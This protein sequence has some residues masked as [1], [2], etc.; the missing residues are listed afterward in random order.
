MRGEVG[1]GNH[2]PWLLGCL[3]PRTPSPATS[4]RGDQRE[5]GPVLALAT[6]TALAELPLPPFYM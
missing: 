2:R 5:P 4:K 1:G 3:A 6:L